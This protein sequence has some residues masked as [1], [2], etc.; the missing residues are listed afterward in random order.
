M[1]DAHPDNAYADDEIDLRELFLVLWE[2]KVLIAMVTGLASIV[3]FVV[4]YQCPISIS[5]LQ[6]LLRNLTVG[7]GGYLG[8][9]QYGGLASLA[10]INL[11]GLSSDGMSKPAIAIEK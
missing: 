2:G 4:G 3:S 11:G 10:G 6:S 1:T 8:L 5:P 7:Q 9:L